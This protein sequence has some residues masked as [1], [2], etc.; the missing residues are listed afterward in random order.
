MG[1][2]R[3][4]D[5][6]LE[7]AI[8][9]VGAAIV[10]ELPSPAR[11]PVAALDERAMRL[12]TEDPEL[13]TALFRLVDVTPACRNLDDLASH[14][15]EFAEN[16]EEP[17]PPLAA[18]MR[19]AHTKPGRLALGAAVAGGVRHMAHRFIAAPSPSEA[20][21]ELR[22]LWMDGI[23][24]SVDLLG[25]ATLTEA[26]ADVYA[27]RCD[28]ALT[29]LADIYREFEPRPLLDRDPIGPL[30]RANL[31]VKITALTPLIRPEAPDRGIDDAAAR[32]RPLLA[33]AKE[34]GAHVHI[35]MESLDSRETTLGLLA[36]LLGDE[37]LRDGPSV[38]V[39]LQAYLRDAEDELQ[40]IMAANRSAG[41]SVPITV[42]LV[43]GA[44]WDHEVV[45][46]GSTAG[47]RPSTPRR[48]SPIGAS[49]RS[50]APLS[51]MPGRT[52][53]R[54][55]SRSPHT[56]CA[57]S[58]T[59]SRTTASREARTTRSSSRSSAASATTLPTRSPAPASG[60]A[61]TAR[62]GTSSRAWRIWCEGSSRTPRTNRSS[63]SRQA[64]RRS[65][66]SWRHRERA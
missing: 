66:R 36:E 61:A 18:A 27:A 15:A 9:E 10:A 6:E 59:R 26:E 23:G 1:D 40:E 48:R 33:R 63:Q 31:S 13:R 7:A 20:R 24:A 28:E 45:E 4:T 57:R 25:E 42:R 39:V 56:T 12:T 49:R 35:D 60:R 55:A 65:T 53:P 8:H 37:A 58:P 19:A 41:R 3:A 38:G 34:I 11:G 32:L 51:T 43:K 17:P 22:R 62:S 50:P 46:A 47:H 5:G 44:Y 2:E 64:A 16:V 14:L 30:P 29:T 21:G 52:R 54:S